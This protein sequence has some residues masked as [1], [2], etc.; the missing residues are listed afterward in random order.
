[1]KRQRHK[2]NDGFTL[3]EVMI[4]V[5][6]L[7]VVFLAATGFTTG[8][9]RSTQA[10]K[11]RVFAI[12]KAI[13]M[14]SEIR[15]FLETP[16]E[17]QDAEGETITRAKTIIDL[18][19]LDDGVVTNPI[20]TIEDGVTD[21]AQALS[22]NTLV[23]ETRD[24]INEDGQLEK[25]AVPWW[26]Y[27]R[28]I[29]VRPLYE[30]GIIVSRDVRIVLVKVFAYRK[31]GTKVS[32]AEVGTVLRTTAEAFP[33]TQ[34]Y[35]V[36][37]L[38]IDTI[39]GWW[40]Y[41]SYVKPFI[42]TCL[43][44]LENRNPGLEIREHWI[45]KA[46]YGR[47]PEYTPYFNLATDSEQAEDH[48]Y[49]YPGTM[50]EI[51]TATNKERDVDK[52]YAPDRVKARINVDEALQ[53]DFDA[54]KNAF[55]YAVADQW[56][57]SLRYAENREYY[58]Q[59][60]GK[61]GEGEPP[62]SLLLDEMSLHPEQYLNA[63]LINIH[64]EL[65]P[66][67]PVHNS[68]DPAKD[69]KDHPGWRVVTHPE[70]IW[71]D[72]QPSG[73]T[74]AWD[75]ENDPEAYIN[76]R[77][78]AYV[79]P[80]QDTSNGGAFYPMADDSNDNDTRDPNKQGYYANNPMDPATDHPHTLQPTEG[81]EYMPGNDP[82]ADSNNPGANNVADDN[83]PIT[84]AVEL[85]DP[86]GKH[87]DLD[88]TGAL[89]GCPPVKVFKIEG[90]FDFATNPNYPDAPAVDPRVDPATYGHPDGKQ[91]DYFIA[92][93]PQQNNPD[94]AGQMYWRFAPANPADGQPAD[95]GV[96]AHRNMFGD[97]RNAT[98]FEL[99]DTPLYSPQ[100]CPESGGPPSFRGLL[101][102]R[103]PNGAGAKWHLYEMEYI[104]CSPDTAADRTY[105]AANLPCYYDDTGAKHDSTDNFPASLKT[106]FARNLAWAPSS[107]DII[108]ANTGAR[109]RV[110]MNGGDG[111][112]WTGADAFT[113][114]R[115][116]RDMV[117]ADIDGDG[118]LDFVVANTN[119]QTNRVVLNDGDGTSWT[120]QDISRCLG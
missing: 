92:E 102:E 114:N 13:S 100:V 78:Y 107:P 115:A 65:M 76:L 68:A 103:D 99:Y 36:Y 112:S 28:Q 57:H 29:S 86:D 89:A 97:A 12:Q 90:G 61:F 62:Y 70:K 16:V 75:D 95:P 53:N 93:C 14:L 58:D 73:G 9:W 10:N 94:Y 87:V 108:A 120:K 1:M 111:T 63:I 91:D 2:P 79:H 119:N 31:D 104:P 45:T 52:Y 98:V 85:M 21:P 64:G 6:V 50:P 88:L 42:E 8:A 23:A 18:D 4:C 60:G 110:Y 37:C 15:S 77:V 5:F 71:Y 22:N 3:V 83:I 81:I 66:I 7:G 67:P 19:A 43:K 105:A 20:L 38:A 25:D 33:T 27:E 35:D 34:V 49:W 41:M 106:G 17:D 96:R 40:V 80:G 30:Q 69:P 117:I 44:D 74:A 32:L 24:Y 109:P 26:K 56:N 72:S 39:P 47:D 59:R 51:V 84:V 48:V 54:D 55:P 116:R 82:N 46:G 113:Q 101:N 11:D 118:D